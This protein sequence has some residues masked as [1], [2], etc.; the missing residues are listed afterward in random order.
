[1]NDHLDAYLEA[2]NRDRAEILDALTDH[3]TRPGSYTPGDHL[4]DAKEPDERSGRDELEA[5]VPRTQ[6][7][8]Q[9]Q[10][11][12]V[13]ACPHGEVDDRECRT[14]MSIVAGTAAPVIAAGKRERKAA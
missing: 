4:R 7:P 1:M 9:S 10:P 11:D 5:I 12:I 2:E 14:C 3:T 8:L 13:I 6:A